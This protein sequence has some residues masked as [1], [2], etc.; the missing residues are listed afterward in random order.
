MTEDA[1]SGMMQSMVTITHNDMSPEMLAAARRGP[2]AAPTDSEMIE[3]LMQRVKSDSQ[4]P[5]FEELGSRGRCKDIQWNLDSC[6]DCFSD[7]RA[8][9][10]TRAE[11]PEEGPRDEAIVP[12]TQCV[13]T[14]GHRSRLVGQEGDCI[15][16]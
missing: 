14:V 3:Y 1:E 5:R 15:R 13:D 8:R 6:K 2:F 11:L 10:G 7:S 12:Q 4:R 9:F 16:I